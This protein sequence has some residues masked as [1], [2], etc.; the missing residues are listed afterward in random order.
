MKPKGMIAPKS[1]VK[2]SKSANKPKGG[3]RTS[4]TS[5]PKAGSKR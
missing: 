5:N 2:M 4:V 3:G 1:G